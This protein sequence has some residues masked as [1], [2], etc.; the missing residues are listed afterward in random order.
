MITYFTHDLGNKGGR[1]HDVVWVHRERGCDVLWMGWNA[2]PEGGYELR[3][4]P[5]TVQ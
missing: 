4:Q 5:C 1:V 2:H 3:T